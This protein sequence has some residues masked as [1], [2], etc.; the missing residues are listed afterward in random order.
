MPC[1]ALENNNNNNNNAVRTTIK[2]VHADT[3]SD[4]VWHMFSFLRE[5]TLNLQICMGSLTIAVLFP[6]ICDLNTIPCFSC[7]QEDHSVIGNPGQHLGDLHRA[8]HLS[9]K[10]PDRSFSHSRLSPSKGKPK[11][12]FGSCSFVLD[13]EPG[14]ACTQVRLIPADREERSS[15]LQVKSDA[16]VLRQQ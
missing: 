10:N 7:L 6:N 4:A 11:D 15:L 1:Q 13:P 3:M 8:L 2:P 5:C 16:C 14:V 12:P 9:A